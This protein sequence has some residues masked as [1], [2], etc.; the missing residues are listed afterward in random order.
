VVLVYSRINSKAKKDAK[1]TRYPPELTWLARAAVAQAGKPMESNPATRTEEIVML[2]PEEWNSDSITTK[3]VRDRLPK[4]EWKT[5]HKSLLDELTRGVP[6]SL[7][8]DHTSK[9]L[10]DKYGAHLLET[11]HFFLSTPLDEGSTSSTP[12]KK[13]TAFVS[14]T[15]STNARQVVTAL[16]VHVWLASGRLA[17]L[18]LGICITLIAMFYVYPPFTIVVLPFVA[19]ALIFF[20]TLTHKSPRMLRVMGYGQPDLWF[21]KATVHQTK[22]PLTQVGLSLFGHFMDRSDQFLVLFQPAYLTRVWTMYELAFWLKKHDSADTITLVPIN[23]YNSLLRYALTLFP[24]VFC[25][26]S[27][28]VSALVIALSPFLFTRLLIVDA[29]ADWA[30]A[31]IIVVIL[32]A[33]VVITACIGYCFDACILRSAKKERLAVEEQLKNFDV[34]LTTA[35]KPE[36]KT[37]VL[38][39]ICNWWDESKGDEGRGSK[40]RKDAALDAF[41]KDV[42]TKVAK[43]LQRLQLRSE[44]VVHC[45]VFIICT[46]VDVCIAIALFMFAEF[47]NPAAWPDAVID[48]TEIVSPAICLID[49]FPHLAECTNSSGLHLKFDHVHCVNSSIVALPDAPTVDCD[50]PYDS[51]GRKTVVV[52]CGIYAAVSIVF[53]CHAIIWSRWSVYFNP[54]STRTAILADDTV[55]GG[56]GRPIG[57]LAVDENGNSRLDDNQLDDNG[58]PTKIVVGPSGKV[59]N[60]KPDGSLIPADA[61]KRKTSSSAANYA[62]GSVAPECLEA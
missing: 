25:L 51:D 13:F 39:E 9:G 44:A 19:Y 10:H 20:L 42:R 26:V 16:L 15:W 40:M 50:G 59:G 37:Y 30:I 35:F 53:S 34:N 45:V 2:L 21:D 18:V 61:A 28:I 33:A 6:L 3:E 58:K 14:H 46:T 55:L 49:T 17:F 5:S 32:V 29:D 31:F 23:T 24:L 54:L 56:D 1:K 11:S 27:T 38:D 41:N 7:L 36:D 62:S 60:I 48:L 43:T 4:D 47:L 22:S 52:I 12:V 57:K 8:L